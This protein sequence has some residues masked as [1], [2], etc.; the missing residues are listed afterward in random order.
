[1]QFVNLRS[2][3]LHVLSVALIAG[4]FAQV[5][6]AGVIETGY[7]VDQEARAARLGRVE[8]MLARDAVARQMESLGVDRSLL[9]ERLDAL[10]DSELAL[11][12]KHMDGQVAGGDALS[13]IGAVFLVLLILELVGAT[14]LFKRI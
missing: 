6:H 11:L 1:M 7:L 10:S 8:V 3:L 2:S 9:A 12:E 5:S 13:L 14:D 4:G